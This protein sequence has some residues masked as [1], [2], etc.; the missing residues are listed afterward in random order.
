MP[1]L[2]LIRY[3]NEG[4]LGNAIQTYGLMQL[5]T[6]DFWVWYDNI[7]FQGD[8]VLICNGWFESLYQKIDTRAL[9]RRDKSLKVS[10]MFEICF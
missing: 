4:N 2:G 1:R 7:S 8:G 5:V 9:G 3:R 6:P 10:L